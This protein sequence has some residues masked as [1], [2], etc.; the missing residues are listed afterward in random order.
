M[1]H[2]LGESEDPGWTLTFLIKSL[3]WVVAPPLCNNQAE[4]RVTARE[5]TVGGAMLNTCGCVRDD[6]LAV[7]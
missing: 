6:A 2:L 5:H 3:G 7:V 1:L 4:G